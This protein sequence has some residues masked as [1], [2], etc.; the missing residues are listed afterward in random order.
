MVAKRVARATS[1]NSPSVSTRIHADASNRAW[2]LASGTSTG[3]VLQPG[4]HRTAAALHRRT[5]GL[6]D[7]PA[8]RATRTNLRGLPKL[9]RYSRARSVRI[10]G[11]PL[12]ASN[13]CRKHRAVA[14]PDTKGRAPRARGGRLPRAPATPSAPDWQKKP[15]RPWVGNR[16]ARVAFSRTAG[17]VFTQAE[18]VRADRPACRAPRAVSTRRRWADRPASRSAESPRSPKPPLTTTSPWTPLC[19]CT[20]RPRR[21]RDDAVPPRG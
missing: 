6:R 5:M 8:R 7:D 12:P 4:N 11:L 2:T 15:A 19:A 21:A 1:N 17:S 16:G 20:A 13:R 3:C 9:S 14:P 10:V 18:A